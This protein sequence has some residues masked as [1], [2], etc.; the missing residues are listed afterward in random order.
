MT[1]AFVFSQLKGG[2]DHDTTPSAHPGSSPAYAKKVGIVKSSR[3]WCSYFLFL[4]VLLIILNSSYEGKKE[5][6]RLWKGKKNLG[7][8][9]VEVGKRKGN[10]FFPS[11]V[12]QNNAIGQQIINSV[13]LS[14]LPY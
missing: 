12:P 3:I 9:T 11:A 13:I 10:F 7:G 1:S 14:L 6:G 5:G 8:N 2:C 4:P